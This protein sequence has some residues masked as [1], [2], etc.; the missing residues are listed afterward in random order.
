V[1]AVAELTIAL[2]LSLLRRITEVDRNIRTREWKPLMGSLLSAQTVGVVGYG[3]IG[4][5]VCQLLRAFGSKVIVYD[6]QEVSLEK[7][8][9]FFPMDDLVEIAD[10]VS[11]HIPHD[12]STHH[13]LNRER[14]LRMKRGSKLVNASRGGLIDEE[15]LYEVLQSGHLAG[16]ALDTFENEPYT[17][18]LTSL[19]QVVLTA[20]MGSYAREARKLMELD[21]G[22]NLF[23]GLVSKGIIK[24][25]AVRSK[26]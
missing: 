26:E 9:E 22:K 4:K 11:L 21:A 19:K 12:A 2:I 16:A 17:G 25:E 14:M 24:A 3:R 5:R 23:Q 18:P 10:V 6:K 15:A 1:V 20:H 8:Y 13:L 7:D